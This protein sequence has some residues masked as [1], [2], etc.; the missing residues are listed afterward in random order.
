MVVAD[1]QHLFSTE[2]LAGG[3]AMHKL[4]SGIEVY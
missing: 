2:V 1:V 4:G 3:V